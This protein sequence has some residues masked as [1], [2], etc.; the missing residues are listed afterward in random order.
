[1]LVNFAKKIKKIHALARIFRYIDRKNGRFLLNSF[2]KSQF[3]YLPLICMFHS[4][5][6]E[7]AINKIHERAL[8]LIYPGNSQLIFNELLKKI[9]PANT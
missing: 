1:M 8:Q 3:S 2:I 7:H 9:K 4:R 5:G 6:M